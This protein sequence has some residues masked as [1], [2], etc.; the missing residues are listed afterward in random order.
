MA[1]PA[2]TYYE[3]D[4][5]GTIRQRSESSYEI[6]ITESH[7]CGLA[8]YNGMI[9]PPCPACQQ[10]RNLS[11]GLKYLQIQPTTPEPPAE[12]PVTPRGGFRLWLDGA[13]RTAKAQPGGDWDAGYLAALHHALTEYDVSMSPAA[14]PELPDTLTEAGKNLP[15][16]SSAAERRD[17]RAP[18]GWAYGDSHMPASAS[19]AG[20]TGTLRRNAEESLRVLRNHAAAF[21]A[22]GHT[23]TA[24]DLDR[25]ANDFARLLARAPG[26]RG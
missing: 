15:Q 7:V 23:S 2:I 24:T 19:P 18:V 26:E 10:S 6:H 20:E 16:S 14:S 22:E 4:K 13:I 11:S 21:R 1:L 8:G 12:R 5:G 3:D 25:A 9:D 17:T